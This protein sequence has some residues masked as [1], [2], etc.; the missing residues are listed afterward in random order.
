MSKDSETIT[1][2]EIENGYLTERSCFTDKGGY[3]SKTTYTPSK[4]KVVET[5]SPPRKTGGSNGAV[6]SSMGKAVALLNSG[7]GKRK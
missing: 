2:R 5:S 4:P 1:V 3:S 7:K 6:P